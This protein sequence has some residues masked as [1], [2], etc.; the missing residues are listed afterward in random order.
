MGLSIG[1]FLFRSRLT[2]KT[3]DNIKK[4]QAKIKNFIFRWKYTD[5]NN[6][7]KI[8]FLCPKCECPLISRQS[9]QANYAVVGRDCPQCGFIAKA[10]ENTFCDYDEAKALIRHYMSKNEDRFR[11]KRK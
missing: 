7:R 10:G 1:Y 4:H 2:T 3:S 8:E 9:W 5:S 11:A 6:I